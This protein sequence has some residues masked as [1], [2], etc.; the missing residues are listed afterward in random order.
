VAPTHIAVPFAAG[1]TVSQVRDSLITVINTADFGLTASIGGADLVNLVASF[2]GTAG[3]G[4][5]TTTS[6]CTPA[7]MAGGVDTTLSGGEFL[8]SE[9]GAVLLAGTADM[10]AVWTANK[11]C[12][13][14]TGYN[15]LRFYNTLAAAVDYL[16]VA[17]WR[18]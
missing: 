11:L 9:N 17:D 8:I 12:V 3:N 2:F 16:I 18:Q 7:G 14:C 5:I 15:A 10:S 13:C 6:G 4:V 1:D